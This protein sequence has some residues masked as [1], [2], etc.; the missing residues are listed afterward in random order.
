MLANQRS[1]LLFA[2]RR[3]SIIIQRS[4]GKTSVSAIPH[5][6]VQTRSMM[7]AC[8]TSGQKPQNLDVECGA[9]DA[10]QDSK[11][12]VCRGFSLS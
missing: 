11:E 9:R 1:D 6:P 3:V 8:I 2:G 7:R 12:V 4:A 10:V 5:T